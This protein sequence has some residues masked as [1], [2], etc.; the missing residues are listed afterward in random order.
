[1]K[2]KLVRQ[3]KGSEVIRNLNVKYGSVDNLKE[4]IKKDPENFLYQHDLENWL[5]YQKHPHRVIEERETIFLNY[6]E[7]RRSDLKLLEIIKKQ[8]PSS[9][10]KLSAI[11]NQ[12]LEEVQPQVQRLAMDGLLKLVPGP[13]DDER[14]VV[15][16]V[17]I[18]FEL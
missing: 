1:M 10:S 5:L 4:L 3:L 11:L 7:I 12:D 13:Q 14:P 17:K 18:E 8:N 2:L 16:F 15:N 9:I 6:S